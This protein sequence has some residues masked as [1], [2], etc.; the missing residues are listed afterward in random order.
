MNIFRF[1]LKKAIK[2]TV[3]LTVGLVCIAAVFIITSFSG[4]Y[5]DKEL[6]TQLFEELP[7]GQEGYEF[8]RHSSEKLSDENTQV[9]KEAEK[10]INEHKQGSIPPVLPKDMTERVFEARFG[11]DKSTGGARIQ[12]AYSLIANTLYSQTNSYDLISKRTEGYSRN[13]RRGVHDEYSLKIS[14][15]LTADYGKVMKMES[16]KNARYD[17]RW[18]DHFVKFVCSEMISYIGI[19][20]LLFSSFS[21]ELQSGRFKAF[22]LTTA[23][24]LRYSSCRLMCGVLQSAFFFTV[25]YAVLSLMTIVMSGCSILSMPAQYLS[26]FEYSRLPMSF[27]EF[28]LYVYLIKLT[29]LL[30]LSA[31][32]MLMSLISD[33]VIV[34]ALT[35]LIPLSVPFA[36]KYLPVHD[37]A[38]QII[39]CDIISMN[40]DTNLVNIGG[41]PVGIVVV[42]FVTVVF[43]ALCFAGITLFLSGRRDCNA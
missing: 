41:S 13:I 2:P 42:F 30:M 14:E 3:L 12:S 36:T 24:A 20:I 17:T 31:A 11:S 6:Y 5:P 4:A 40:N 28:V 23:G 22:K 26:G 15:K 27:G 1:M 8:A 19:F 10:Y 25:Y 32:V 16:K 43:S 33:R 18:A 39:S 21:A 9:L 38:K 29:F 37:N 7:Q 34:S 35:G